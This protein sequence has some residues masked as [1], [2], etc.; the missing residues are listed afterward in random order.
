MGV[1]RLY[2]DGIFFSNGTRVLS[3][4]CTKLLW[5]SLIDDFIVL[6]VYLLT[7]PQIPTHGDHVSYVGKRVP[8]TWPY[9]SA[10]T[11]GYHV[12]CVGLL[13]LVGIIR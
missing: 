4:V 3:F 9:G 5:H 12:L 11:S 6:V 2:Q 7:Q 1:G 10:W 8:L 13:R